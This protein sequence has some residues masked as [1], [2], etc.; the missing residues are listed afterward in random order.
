MVVGLLTGD[1]ENPFFARLVS[2]CTAELE[3]AGYESVLAMRRQGEVS[4]FHLLETLASRQVDGLLIWSESA[5]EIRTWLEKNPRST[6]V[7]VLGYRIEQ[8][9]S[10]EA[11][12][13]QGVR[14]ALSHF[15]DQGSK[16]IGYLAPLSSLMTTGDPRVGIYREFV[17]ARESE[18]LVYTYDG[19]AND[20]KAARIRAEEIACSRP[21]ERPDALLCFNDMTAFGALMGL[22]RRGLRVPNDIAII[23]CD[24]IP[25]VSQLD[26]PLTSI[27]YPIVELCR[28]AVEMLIGRIEF[29]AEGDSIDPPRKYKI[30][31]APLSV[32]ESSIVSQYGIK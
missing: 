7:V 26:V 20:P 17:A 11:A 9:D 18:P 2:L 12:L 6:N 15:Q 22:R 10:V 5:S 25:L 32:R 24:D 4:D 1:V 28:S 31:P 16:R 21:T 27:A 3:R 8:C 30:I 23:G 13:G 19:S 29:K 14:D